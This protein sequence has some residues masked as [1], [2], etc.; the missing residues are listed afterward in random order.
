[1]AAENRSSDTLT[2]LATYNERSNIDHM[3][4]AILALPCRCDIL[5]VDD[6]SSDG[7]RQRLEERAAREPRLHLVFRAGKLGVG[8]AHRLG[9]LYARQNGYARIVTLDADLSHDPLDIPRLLAALDAGADVALGSRFVPQGKLDYV[10]YRRVVS[11]TG[12]RLARTLLRLPIAEFTTSLR[13]ARLDRVPFGLVET[14]AQNGYGF[15]VTTAVRMAR[16]RLRLTEI[17]IHFRNRHTGH[18]KLPKSE[19]VRSAVNLFRLALD[20]RPL[21]QIA[22][23]AMAPE[24]CR[25]CGAAY[26]VATPEGERVCLGCMS[27]GAS[28]RRGPAAAAPHTASLRKSG[29]A[30]RS[31][32]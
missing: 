1:L 2:F 27:P 12:N 19:I 21:A 24:A 7:T 30:S 4:D 8:S 5:V 23:S 16:Q 18:S 9:W 20:R 32:R 3:L 25:H 10:G 17:P 29:T 6:N 31:T 13:A 22:G 15:F 28:T 14:V 26:V 11:R